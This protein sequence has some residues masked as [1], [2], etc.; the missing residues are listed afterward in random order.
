MENSRLRATMAK[1]SITAR[2]LAEQVEVDAKTVER[3][4][5]TGRV[6]YTRTA[7]RVAEVLEEDP[8]FLWPTV[9]RGR[10]HKAV[11]SEVVAVYAQRAEVSPAMWREFFDRATN[12]LDILVYAANHLHESVP[13]FDELLAENAGAGVQVRVALGDPASA[14]VAARGKEERFG[15]GIQSRCELAL[16]YYRP[17]IGTPNVEVRTHDTTLYN[18]IFRVDDDVLVNAHIWGM[19]AFSAPVWHLRHHPPATMVTSYQQSF[20]A[21][22]QRA[23]PVR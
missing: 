2:A 16:L 5:N 15:H 14:R 20:E 7:V 17:L 9:R 23:V 4:V 13:G 18:S 10:T 6:P 19:N 1:R 11:A 21:V 3:W 22:W 12:N 8:V